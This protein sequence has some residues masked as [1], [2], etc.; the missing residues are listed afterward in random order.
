MSRFAILSPIAIYSLML[1]TATAQ[2]PLLPLD[3]SKVVSVESGSKV[4]VDRNYVLDTWPDT[5]REHKVFLQSSIQSGARFEVITP[6]FV[7]VLTPVNVEYNQSARLLKS[8]F[9]YVDMEP[10]HPY[11]IHANR[12][13]Q[14]CIA[15]QKAVQTGETIEFGRYGI[16]LWSSHELPIRQDAPPVIPLITIPTIDI[17]EET[18][19]HIII[20]AGTEEIY[21]GHVDTV[22]MQDG[23]TMFCHMGN[24]A[25]RSPRPAGC[26]Q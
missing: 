1:T 6:G 12:P 7:V 19:R 15:L 25:C 5:L 16:A 18:N 9:S 3:D 11:L 13:G 8:G 10:F 24:R 22:L 20:A 23:K 2:V 14:S 26:K 21:Q 17:S 4:W